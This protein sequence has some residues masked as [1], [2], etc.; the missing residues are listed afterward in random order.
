MARTENVHPI[1][2][3]EEMRDCPLC[4]YTDGFHNVFRP[5]SRQGMLDWL[6]VCPGCSECFDAGL[7]TPAPDTDG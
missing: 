1:S 7:K 5:S 3:G 2:I 6:F 4:G